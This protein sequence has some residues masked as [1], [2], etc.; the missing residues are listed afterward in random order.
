MSDLGPAVTK[1]VE[2]SKV[3]KPDWAVR[4]AV[5]HV[6]Q[7]FDPEDT[8]GAKYAVTQLG[9]AIK[10]AAPGLAQQVMLL[11]IGALVES[12]APPEL[13]F[14][15]VRDGLVDMLKTSARFGDR[16]MEITDTPL[17]PDAIHQVKH[18]LGKKHPKELAAWEQLPSR[19]LAAVACLSRSPKLRKQE[20]EKADLIE[21]AEPFYELVE[22]VT[23]LSQ[24]AR[25]LDENQKLLVIHPETRRG[26]RFTFSD[27]TTILEL[28]VLILDQIVG[29]PSK[30][31]LKAAKPNPRA[32]RLLTDPDYEV[33]NPP[34]VNVPFHTLQWTALLPDGTF[35]DPKTDKHSHHWVWLEGLP[36]EIA[37]FENERVILMVPPVMKRTAVVEPAFSALS[38]SLK[39]TAKLSQADVDRLIEKMT[40]A[41]NARAAKA[42]QHEKDLTAHANRRMEHEA[43]ANAARAAYE[44]AAKAKTK[45]PAKGAAKK[46][47]KAAAKKTAKKKASRR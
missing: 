1:L 28:Y 47:P 16:C 43:V 29:D 45:K 8:K 14:P 35:R 3:G 39:L 9:G 4:Q 37:P 31:L 40:K 21:A 15:F 12:G 36:L 5:G 7:A 30:G 23:F 25:V 2:I 33:K 17:V 34:E 13:A 27:I 38:P 11:A 46:A 24:I 26:W 42:S 19:C 32:V 41:N 10:T 44:E 18:I 6:L 20:R 22:E